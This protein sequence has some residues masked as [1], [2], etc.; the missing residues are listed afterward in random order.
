[1]HAD[2]MCVQRGARC[3]SRCGRCGV[4]RAARKL[5]NKNEADVLIVES[6]TAVLQQI[7][8]GAGQRWRRLPRETVAAVQR[9]EQHLADSILRCSQSS[10]SDTLQ[11]AQ[12]RGGCYVMA[13]IIASQR[14]VFPFAGQ[15]Q[16]SGAKLSDIHSHGPAVN[17]RAQPSLD[18]CSCSFYVLQSVQ[19][20]VREWRRGGGG[21]G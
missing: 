16:A 5:L 6:A 8:Q 17:N 10:R 2:V 20:G 15:C 12:V 19:S 11:E 7:A 18:A 3:D 14:S 4:E 21:G 9:I 1:M 13:V